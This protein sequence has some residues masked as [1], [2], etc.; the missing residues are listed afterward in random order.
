MAAEKAEGRGGER[1]GRGGGERRRGE[2]EGRRGG[3][4]REE[5]MDERPVWYGVRKQELP[6]RA[7]HSHLGRPALH[8]LLRLLSARHLAHERLSQQHS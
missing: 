5:R 7:V 2:E 6:G 8:E 1:G 4:E 3:E